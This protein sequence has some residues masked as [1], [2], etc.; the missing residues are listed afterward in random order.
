[1]LVRCR[2]SLRNLIKLRRKRDE[3]TVV[4]HPVGIQEILKQMPE[5]F[6]VPLQEHGF[7]IPRGPDYI[8]S[9]G[10][11]IAP[12]QGWIAIGLAGLE[13]A[14]EGNLAAVRFQIVDSHRR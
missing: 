4:V 9:P 10:R 12:A 3:R 1:M 2:D 14:K 7:V 6:H 11:D 8:H 5:F 13:R